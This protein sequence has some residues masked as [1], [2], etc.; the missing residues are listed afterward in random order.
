MSLGRGLFARELR[1]ALRRR[2]ES[3]VQLGFAVIVVGLF[4]FAIGPEPDLLRRIAPGVIWVA[5][6]LATLLPLE[7]LF[8]DDEREGTLELIAASGRPLTLWGLAKATGHWLS[9]GLPLTLALPF[10]GLLYGLETSSLWAIAASLLL[11]TPTLSLIGAVAAAL[12]LGARRGAALVAVILLPLYIPV[13]IFG[14]TAVEAAIGGYDVLT[15]LK[16]LGAFALVS[17]VLAPLATG[18]ALSQALD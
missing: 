9:S 6:L 2:R 10:A 11:G 7:R 13:L 5:A 12:V 4:P 14:T 17:L 18:L 3:L 16:V 1:L 15:H 8:A